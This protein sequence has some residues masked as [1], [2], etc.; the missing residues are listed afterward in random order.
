[1]KKLIL[2]ATLVLSVNIVYSQS[3]YTYQTSKYICHNRDRSGYWSNEQIGFADILIVLDLDN[4][5]IT[6]NSP[7]S[8]FV[9]HIM[10]SYKRNNYPYTYYVYDCKQ[11]NVPFT[12]V[13]TNNNKEGSQSITLENIQTRITYSVAFL[14]RY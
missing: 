1:M 12:I 10:S 4:D 3:Y 7:G 8:K 9:Y 6:F 14:G 13:I 11:M 2:I 5:I